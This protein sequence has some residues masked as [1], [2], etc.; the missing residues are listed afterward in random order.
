LAEL[1][2]RPEVQELVRKQLE[3][4]WEGWYN[5]RLLALNNKT[6]LHAARTKSGRERLEA[7]LLDCERDNELADDYNRVDLATLR[8]KLGL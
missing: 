1:Q 7:L 5:T 4:N 6:P 3:A 2:S 8:K